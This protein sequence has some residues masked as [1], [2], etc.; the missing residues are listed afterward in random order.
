MKV[1]IQKKKIKMIKKYL[2]QQKKSKKIHIIM[3]MK[4]MK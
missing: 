2:L 4:I 3:K 1:K